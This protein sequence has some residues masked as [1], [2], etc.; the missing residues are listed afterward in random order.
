MTYEAPGTK[1]AGADTHIGA[2]GTSLNTPFSSHLARFA[3]KAVLPGFSSARK[4]RGTASSR[5][6]RSATLGLRNARQQFV[7]KALRRMSG[8][9]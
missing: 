9:A 1:T 3:E 4:Q 8:K 6:E 7:E 2:P 5:K